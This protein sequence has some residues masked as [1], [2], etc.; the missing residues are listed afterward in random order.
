MTRIHM[1]G[2]NNKPLCGNVKAINPESIT[3]N[4]KKVTCTN[5]IKSMKAGI[6]KATKKE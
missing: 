3:D 4:K 6:A 5:C 2:P 1:E